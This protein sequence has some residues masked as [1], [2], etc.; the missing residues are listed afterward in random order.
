MGHTR[1][2]RRTRTAFGVIGY[3]S[4]GL[5]QGRLR[6]RCNFGQ[7]HGVA[8]VDVWSSSPRVDSDKVCCAL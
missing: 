5:G 3:V 7:M 1:D 8:Q 6:Y 4:K 2:H